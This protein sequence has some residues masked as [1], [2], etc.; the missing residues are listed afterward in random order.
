MKNLPKA[1]LVSMLVVVVGL[2]LV[3]RRSMG[4]RVILDS[5]PAA[6]TSKRALLAPSEKWEVLSAV[7]GTQMAHTFGEKATFEYA[8]ADPVQSGVG[9]RVRCAGYSEVH[10]G[11]LFSFTS[12]PI[13][14]HPL[15]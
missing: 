9:Y 15:Y 4:N 1:A 13:A 14:H 2:M 6:G 8:R 11:T 5:L 7:F 3:L 12:L 10:E